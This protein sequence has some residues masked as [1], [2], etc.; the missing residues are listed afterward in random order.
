MMKDKMT[1]AW[2]YVV[3]ARLTVV[4]ELGEAEKELLKELN[5]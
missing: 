1:T 3:A 2:A 4:L 5:K